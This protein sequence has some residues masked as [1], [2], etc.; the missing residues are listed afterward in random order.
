MSSLRTV[1]N[2]K[3]RSAMHHQGFVW[4][5]PN[6]GWSTLH[7][8]RNGDQKDPSWQKRSKAGFGDYSEAVP[9]RL[10]DELMPL[11]V[12]LVVCAVVLPGSVPTPASLLET[13]PARVVEAGTLGATW[14]HLS[15]MTVPLVLCT[16]PFSTHRASGTNGTSDEMN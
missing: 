12:A 15:G 5:T 9:S 13:V 3:I 10:T 16:N 4:Q 2:T 11:M 8:T 14:L 1:W 6:V 7:R